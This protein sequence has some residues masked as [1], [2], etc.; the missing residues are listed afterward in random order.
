MPEAILTMVLCVL[1]NNI[2][3][4]SGGSIEPLNSIVQSIH[5]SQPVITHTCAW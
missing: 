3:L 5:L 1:L 4:N 2:D